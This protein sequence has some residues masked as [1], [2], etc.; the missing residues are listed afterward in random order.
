M[1]LAIALTI[2]HVIILVEPL[3][4]T[5]RI[6]PPLSVYSGIFKAAGS[7]IQIVQNLKMRNKAIVVLIVY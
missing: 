5:N 4:S 1:T 3:L 7:D 2:V 6:T